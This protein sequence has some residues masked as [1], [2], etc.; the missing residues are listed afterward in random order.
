MFSAQG[1]SSLTNQTFCYQTFCSFN[2]FSCF[3]NQIKCFISII[4]LH[5]IIY[6]TYRISYFSLA[7]TRYIWV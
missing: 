5:R 2:T 4:I 7:T 6:C 3:L 1:S